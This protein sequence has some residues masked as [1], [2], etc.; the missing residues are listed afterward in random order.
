MRKDLGFEMQHPRIRE[1]E[2]FEESHDTLESLDLPILALSPGMGSGWSVGDEVSMVIPGGLRVICGVRSRSN[3]AEKVLLSGLRV[4]FSELLVGDGEKH[5]VRRGRVVPTREKGR[6]GEASDV[7]GKACGVAAEAVIVHNEGR[8]VE[9][10][11]S[12]RW[13]HVPSVV[14][15]ARGVVAGARGLSDRVPSLAKEAWWVP[16]EGRPVGVGSRRVT[17]RRRG[18]SECGSSVARQAWRVS[19]AGAG[20][21]ARESMLTPGGAGVLP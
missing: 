12:E 7:I 4:S 10:R 9:P 2:L 14:P 15:A 13:Y 1:E 18:V 21:I 20:V 11:R 6:V 5:V 8:A 19:P 3:S 16:H 17:V